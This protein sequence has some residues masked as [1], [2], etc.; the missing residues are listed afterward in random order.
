MATRT[1][2]AESNF[3]V[4]GPVPADAAELGGMTRA[5]INCTYVLSLNS[6]E[7]KY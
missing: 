5:D 1:L 7:I 3:N 6:T 2:K 4:L